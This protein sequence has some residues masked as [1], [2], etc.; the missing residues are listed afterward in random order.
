MEMLHAVLH[1]HT[2]CDCKSVGGACHEHFTLYQPHDGMEAATLCATFSKCGFRLEGE[3]MSRALS[4]SLSLS[5]NC[6]AHS[7]VLHNSR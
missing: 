2:K 3:T 7:M 4:F 5:Q 1:I 6:L